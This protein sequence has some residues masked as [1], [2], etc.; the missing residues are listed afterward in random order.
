MTLRQAAQRAEIAMSG[1]L[2]AEE[3]DAALADLR[4]ALRNPTHDEPHS[5]QSVA[6]FT[7][8]PSRVTARCNGGHLFL[9]V[10]PA[11]IE[12]SR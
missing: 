9:T 2:T 1:G 6:I 11:S 7:Q 8:D 5:P 4:H 12:E 3:Y 10:E